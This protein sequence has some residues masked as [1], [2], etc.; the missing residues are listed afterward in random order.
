MLAGMFALSAQLSEEEV[1]A[2][3]NKHVVS[4]IISVSIRWDYEPW[5]VC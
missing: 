5:H 3:M 4:E 2:G 1:D